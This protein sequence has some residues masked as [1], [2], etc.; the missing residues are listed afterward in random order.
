MIRIETVKSSVTQSECLNVTG[1]ESPNNDLIRKTD[2]REDWKV[3]IADVSLSATDLAHDD[4]DDTC[5]FKI[6]VKCTNR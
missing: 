4:D 2:D 1:K 6:S 5:T 3:M